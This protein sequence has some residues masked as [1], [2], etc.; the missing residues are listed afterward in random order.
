MIN[1]MG[2]QPLMFAAAHCA[3]KIHECTFITVNN[4]D[5]T[6][7]I[8]NLEITALSHTD[9]LGS[10]PVGCIGALTWIHAASDFPLFWLNWHMSN[11]S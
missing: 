5:I 1:Y 8:K 7:S 2:P 11:L 3:G 10:N 4:N 9:D 6:R